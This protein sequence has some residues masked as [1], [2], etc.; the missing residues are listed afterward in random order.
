MSLGSGCPSFIQPVTERRRWSHTTARF[1]CAWWCLMS[2]A[3][4]IAGT[5]DQFQAMHLSLAGPSGT[6]I[7]EIQRRRK[8]EDCWFAPITHVMLL[9]GESVVAVHVIFLFPA[10]L[11]LKRFSHSATAADIAAVGKFQATPYD[12]YLYP[13]PSCG[14]VIEYHLRLSSAPRWRTESLL[15]PLRMRGCPSFGE[16]HCLQTT[17]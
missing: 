8:A 5:S 13:R 16:V 9:D 2:A 17:S 15:T 6:G 11:L 12:S 4:R 14:C 7:V 10:H 1:E 3:S